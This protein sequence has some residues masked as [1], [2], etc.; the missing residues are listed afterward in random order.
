[1]GVGA[2]YAALRDHRR[3]DGRRPALSGP[4]SED[5]HIAADVK[6]NIGTVPHA[7]RFRER[8]SLSRKADWGAV[9]A[10]DRA[11]VSRFGQDFLSLD[12]VVRPRKGSEMPSGEFF[13]R[14]GR[15]CD[16]LS[17]ARLDRLGFSVADRGIPA[18]NDL[19]SSSPHLG[20]CW[21]LLAQHRPDC[22][23]ADPE[24]S[25]QLAPA[26]IVSIRANGCFLDRREL[27]LPG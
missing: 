1:L 6:G 4:A 12:C 17:P 14:L 24:C 18:G 27:A 15:F 22:F 3:P 5:R 10:A 2:R 7:H 13:N 16:R 9:G 20:Q 19:G 8:P 25:G 26:L 11:Q 23:V 21:G